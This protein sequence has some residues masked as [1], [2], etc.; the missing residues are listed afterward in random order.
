MALVRA[1]RRLEPLTPPLRAPDSSSCTPS[2]RARSPT[3]SA[4][5]RD[6][7]PALCSGD[8]RRETLPSSRGAIRNDRPPQRLAP[9]QGRRT[10]RGGN[11]GSSPLGYSEAD[12]SE[13]DDS[14]EWRDCEGD[15]SGGDKS[16]EEEAD[17]GTT[18]T[19]TYAGDW[20]VFPGRAE[21]SRKRATRR[22]GNRRSRCLVSQGA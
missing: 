10:A 13:A 11:G 17:D 12:D 16:E 18:R 7:R 21:S 2:A 19:G 3:P 1:Q 22:K 15:D 5:A 9:R 8:Y 6:R 4:Q 20:L 14:E